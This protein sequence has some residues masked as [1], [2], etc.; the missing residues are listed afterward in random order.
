MFLFSGPSAGARGAVQPGQAGQSGTLGA[1][2]EEGGA[3]VEGS[4]NY[5]SREAT[6]AAS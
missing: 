6:A 2:E 1:E 4:R 5:M 3:L